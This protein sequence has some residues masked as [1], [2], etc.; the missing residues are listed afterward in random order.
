MVFAGGGMRSAH[1]GG[2]LHTLAT[3]LGITSPDIAIG[4][5]ADAG[6]VVYYAAKNYDGL[7]KVWCELVS[8]PK[9]ISF[10]RPWKIMDVDYF[11]DTILKV[12]APMD[13]S[14][15]KQTSIEWLVP[16]TNYDTGALR[17]VGAN[18]GVDPYEVLR[19][20]KSLPVFFGKRFPVLGGIYFDGELG[21]TLEDHVN[22]AI[23]RGARRILVVSHIPHR[24][25]LRRIA[26]R[27]YSATTPAP[28][29]HAI[30]RDTLTE[31]TCLTLPGITIQCVMPQNLSVGAA[32]R[33]QAKLRATFERG[34]ADALALETELRELFYVR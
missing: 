25:L 13:L 34:V 2:F 28:L 5:S 12:Q 18:D 26:M 4:S 14:L 3:Q 31:A 32:T 30:L 7:K 21:A 19:I 9:F 11:I 10:W 20:A 33:D 1:G 23:A 6:N 29:R 8:T 27:L 16:I 22:Q 17:Y 24:T 15:L